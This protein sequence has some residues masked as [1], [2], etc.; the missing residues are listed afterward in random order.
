MKKLSVVAIVI[1]ACSTYVIQAGAQTAI[2]TEGVIESKS[3]GFKYPNGTIQISAAKDSLGE[4]NCETDEIAKFNGENWVCSS[5]VT[6]DQLTVLEDRILA[7]EQLITPA[8]DDFPPMLCEGT[9]E[10]CGELLPF[11]PTEGPGYENYPINGET[12]ENQYRSYVRRDLMMLIKYA[13]AKV[14]CEAADWTFGNGG[15]IGLGDMSEADGAIP[16]T[17]IGNPAHPAGSH[18]DGLDIDVAYFQTDTVDNKLRAICTVEDYHCA[19]PPHL[20]DADRTALFL[21]YLTE[22][23]QLR[24]I[25]VDGQAG[26]AIDSAVVGLCADG[27][28]SESECDALSQVLVYEVV[29]QGTGW[30]RFHYHRVHISISPSAF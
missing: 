25:G 23:P 19:E 3:G 1:L 10:Y 6:E 30:F 22:H 18:I 11:E 12:S 24:V 17:S 15:P 7:L 28:L 21:G 20:L 4:L 26:L 5:A 29:D 13:A 16:G 8:C 27:T 14:A 9:G 2:S